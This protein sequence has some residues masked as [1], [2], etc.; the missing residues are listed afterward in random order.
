MAL[1]G[2]SGS[3]VTLGY[4]WPD[5]LA[6]TG[7]KLGAY[8][9]LCWLV[10]LVGPQGALTF[11]SALIR[12]AITRKWCYG[13]IC[14]CVC[15]CVWGPLL[16]VIHFFDKPYLN[17]TLLY[18]NWPLTKP[19]GPFIIHCKRASVLQKLTSTFIFGVNRIN[20]YLWAHLYN[21]Y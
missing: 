5:K 19:P 21:L 10:V 11:I 4:R 17:S 3:C 8:T 7:R 14:A 20:F 9:R 1:M 2:V 12:C 6:G 13:G 15:V 16:L 18:E